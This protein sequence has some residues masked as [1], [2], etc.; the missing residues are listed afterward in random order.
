MRNSRRD[1]DDIGSQYPSW[2]NP[3]YDPTSFHGFPGL[4]LAQNVYNYWSGYQPKSYLDIS[5]PHAYQQATVIDNNGVTTSRDNS[6][7]DAE[8]CSVLTNVKKPA[9]VGAGALASY[10][11]SVKAETMVEQSLKSYDNSAILV[12]DRINT[13]G[14]MTLFAPAPGDALNSRHGRECVLK[15]LHLNFEIANNGAQ[16]TSTDINQAVR[17]Y[18]MLVVYDKQQNGADVTI[19]DVLEATNN[20]G[21]PNWIPQC[22]LRLNN[23]NRFLI[24]CDYSWSMDPVF[25]DS[26]A[27]FTKASG[28]FQAYS[29]NISKD[30]NLLTTFNAGTAETDASIATGGLKLVACS[31]AAGTSNDWG[32][33]TVRSRV[34]Y[35]ST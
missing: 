32:N 11:T 18:R 27:G 13:A 31:N 34:R 2:S 14:D 26:S 22:P 10:A 5:D 25:N 6:K 29:G 15:E 16:V 1:E 17:H 33:L 28:A 24:I 12:P 7:Y 20:G 8:K 35:I 19:S 30:L 9:D 3:P 23:R 4:G 21:T